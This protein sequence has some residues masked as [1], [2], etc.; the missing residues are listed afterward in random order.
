M[1]TVK[2]YWNNICILHK[3]EVEFLKNLQDNLKNKN[4]NLEITYFGIGNPYK[5]NEYLKMEDAILPDI[6][7]S[8]DLEIYED[9]NIFSKFSN[10]LYNI[11]EYFHIKDELKTSPICF[12]NRLLPFLVIPLVFAYN[13]SFNNTADSIENI[14]FNNVKT[15]IGGINNSGAKSIV[16]AIWSEYGKSSVEQFLSNSTILDM[17][18]LSFMDV[19]N[20]SANLAITP[21]IYA[22]RADNK[23]LY[24]AYPEDGAIALPSYI[25]ASKSLNEETMIEIVSAITSTDFC[26]SFVKS[27][28]LL[29][30]LKES[31][32]EPLVEKNNFKFLYPSKEWFNTVS[33]EEF[34]ELYN[35]YI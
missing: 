8:T 29:A 2:L 31:E 14:I 17:P 24:L 13:N 6:I 32:N 11:C 4:I 7:V 35:Q 21:S 16:K 10:N 1:K 26:N 3:L 9:K 12:D 27:A 34:F 18:I 15:V 22:N 30:C 25:T 20:G 33:S 28:S 5:L 19:K 23:N